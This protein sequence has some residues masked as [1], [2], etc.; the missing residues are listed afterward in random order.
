M[1]CQLDH[2]LN[3]MYVT[4]LKHGV[5]TIDFFKNEIEKWIFNNN[6]THFSALK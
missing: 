6:Y 1:L 2:V 5:N 4:G 3:L